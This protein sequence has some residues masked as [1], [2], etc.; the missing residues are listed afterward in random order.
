[1]EK[2]VLIKRPISE[3]FEYVADCRNSKGYLG[4]AFYFEAV[5]PPP[6]GIGTKAVA[7]GT[8]MGIPIRLNYNM[9]EFQINRLLRLV[10][11]PQ[12]LNGIPVDSEALWRFAE[13]E[14]D[15]TLVSFRLEI[16][17]RLNGMNMF[18]GWLSVPIIQAAEA[19]VSLMLDKALWK[20][21]TTLE[22]QSKAVA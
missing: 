14:P 2:R 11:P 20:L 21:K 4:K 1:M 16:K 12:T 8:Y 13:K 18:A 22:S 3:V 10:A 9:T 15:V 5:T 6:Y 7:V 17:P 19:S